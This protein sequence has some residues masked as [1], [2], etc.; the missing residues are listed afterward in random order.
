MAMGQ[1]IARVGMCCHSHAMH[2]QLSTEGGERL[3][4]M[5]YYD[6]A[7][8]CG[9]LCHRTIDCSDCYHELRA[10]RSAM[11]RTCTHSGPCGGDGR[12]RGHHVGAYGSYSHIGG[13]QRCSGAWSTH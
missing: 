9:C 7:D 13:I 6:G 4:P 10:L 1:S 2:H 5:R 3:L 8:C 11:H 12:E